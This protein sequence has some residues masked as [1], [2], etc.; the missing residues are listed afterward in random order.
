MALISNQPN[1]YASTNEKGQ[2]DLAIFAEASV[3]QI[4]LSEYQTVKKSYS[5]LA[6]SN[7]LQL[8]PLAFSF[9]AVTVTASKWNDNNKNQTSRTTS[10]AKKRFNYKIHKL[11]QIYW[12]IRR[13]FY[14]KSQLGGGS[15]MIRGFSTNRLLYVVDGVR[16]N[17]AIF[18]GGN[19]Q[20]VISLDAFSLD[21]TDILFGPSSVM[22]GSDAL[23]AVMSLRLYNRN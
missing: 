9:D 20:N 7:T 5:E 1:L 19:L 16:M 10:L 4:I 22:Y 15:P 17:N 23:G 11:P 8:S 13:G 14:S 12:G 2:V 21:K 3:I 6:A 18:R